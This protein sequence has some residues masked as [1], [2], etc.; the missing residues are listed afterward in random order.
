MSRHV[1]VLSVPPD[2]FHVI[3]LHV[4]VRIAVFVG[5]PEGCRYHTTSAVYNLVHYKT[6][7]QKIMSFAL[8][9]IEV[10]FRKFH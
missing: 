4:K 9:P 2:L 3:S 8:R 10:N 5:C 1:N 6:I 7:E